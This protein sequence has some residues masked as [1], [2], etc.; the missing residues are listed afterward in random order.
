M[1]EKIKLSEALKNNSGKMK[2]YGVLVYILMPIFSVVSFVL[3]GVYF[4]FSMLTVNG[5]AT[6]FKAENVMNKFITSAKGLEVGEKLTRAEINEFGLFL[7][8]FGLLAIALGVF[9]LA[10]RSSLLFFEKKSIMMAFILFLASGAVSLVTAL[11]F[12]LFDYK[13]IYMIPYLA[14][15]AVQI[16][17]GV[18]NYIYLKKISYEFTI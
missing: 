2:W 9:T 1:A 15:A 11:Y 18:V 17:F 6:L 13:F 3:G 14:L 10:A 5:F 4:V 7:F 16:A 8:S 12:W